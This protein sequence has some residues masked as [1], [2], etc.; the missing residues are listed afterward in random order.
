MQPRR[1]LGTELQYVLDKIMV[2]HQLELMAAEAWRLCK[3][4]THTLLP[5]TVCRAIEVVSELQDWGI[6]PAK[7]TAADRGVMYGPLL[8]D[9][10]F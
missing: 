2:H 7:A 5:L 3:Y 4:H 1:V 8:A 9:L 6:A 10:F